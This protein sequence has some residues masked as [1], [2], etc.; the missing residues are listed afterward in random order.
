MYLRVTHEVNEK[1]RVTHETNWRQR[2]LS[3]R[4]KLGKKNFQN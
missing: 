1:V 2:N 3:K 4:P